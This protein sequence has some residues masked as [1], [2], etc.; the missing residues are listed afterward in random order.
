MSCFR[1]VIGHGFFELNGF[2]DAGQ[3]DAGDLRFFT[4]LLQFGDVRVALH[5]AGE[6]RILDLGVVFDHDDEIV[7]PD[8]LGERDGVV[9][10]VD[11]AGII[12]KRALGDERG[13]VG[14]EDLDLLVEILRGCADRERGDRIAS[15]R[16]GDRDPHRAVGQRL[17]LPDRGVDLALDRPVRIPHHYPFIGERTGGA[18]RRENAEAVHIFQFEV[19]FRVDRERGDG[20]AGGLF[21]GDGDV[22][23]EREIN[24]LRGEDGREQEKCA[25]RAEFFQVRNEVHW[26]CPLSVRSGCTARLRRRARRP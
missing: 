9:P 4:D 6:R 5:D 12:Q 22:L 16:G 3:G 20:H 1:I 17:E 10:Q 26:S 7:C 8:R 13:P 24:G 11:P 14:G 19:H 15:G 18:V 21:R 23:V 2:A 25:G